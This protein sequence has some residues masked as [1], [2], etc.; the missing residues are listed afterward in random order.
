MSVGPAASIVN[1]WDLFARRRI[2]VLR[3]N[4]SIRR[5]AMNSPRI[6]VLD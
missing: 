6:T 3:Q 2:R 1:G 4:N 5:T